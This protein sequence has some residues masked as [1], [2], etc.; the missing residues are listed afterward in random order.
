MDII[1]A[2][3]GDIV[4]IPR[5][6][7][8]PEAYHEFDERS[9]WAI[10][11]AVAAERPLLVRGEPGTGKSQLARAA[12]HSMGRVFIS[13]V[14][15]AHS[16]CRD[17]QYHFD[18]VARLGEAQALCA[19][20]GECKID[21]ELDPLK[22]LSPGPLWWAFDWASAEK[23]YAKGNRCTRRPEKTNDLKPENGA[24]LL[25]DE[26]DKADADLPNGL[27]ETL[28][29]GAFTVPYRN[30]SVG[31]RGDKLPLVVITTNEERTLPAAFLRRCM[32]LQLRLP[33]EREELIQSLCN[34]GKVHFAGEIGEKVRTEAANQLV[35]DRE[36]LKGR[37]LPAPG[38][39]EYLDMLRAL[40]GICGNNEEK[41][42][43]A[44]EK[45]KDFA[46]SKNPDEYR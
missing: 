42:L 26:I 37:G 5:T 34:R 9:I 29:N 28:G 25:I 16:E 23:Q 35:N 2:K 8:W 13:D 6:G 44:L 11:A 38:Q 12:A 43:D 14:V 41:Q 31:L 15:H 46:L 3:D 30:E 4:Q 7:S 18:A 1:N 20:K 33:E 36:S 19:A 45:I 10:K 40:R 32:V 24:V 39:A 21:E 22:F 27:L 17:L